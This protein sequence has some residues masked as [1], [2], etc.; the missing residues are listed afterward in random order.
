M[1][2]E[3]AVAIATQGALCVVAAVPPVCPRC[4]TPLC[5]GPRV[6]P[7][8]ITLYLTSRPDPASPDP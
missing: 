8:G 5:A 6:L 3:S 7:V 1:P 2:G 4:L